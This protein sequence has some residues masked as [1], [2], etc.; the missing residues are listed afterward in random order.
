M[1]IISPSG[2]INAEETIDRNN[3]RSGYRQFKYVPT[4]G[5]Y[6]VMTGMNVTRKSYVKNGGFID[7]EINVGNY[8][9][10]TIKNINH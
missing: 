7:Y 6:G 10:N 3:K 1:K 9:G 4:T 2:S 8:T 5:L